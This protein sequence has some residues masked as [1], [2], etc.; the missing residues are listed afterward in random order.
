[1]RCWASRTL[2]HGSRCSS[3]TTR[4]KSFARSLNTKHW[5]RAVATAL[6][7]SMLIPLPGCG[8]PKLQRASPGAPL[9]ETFNVWTTPGNSAQLGIDEFFNDP[10]LSSLIFQALNGN[11]QLKIMTQDIAIANNEIMRRRGAYLPF[12]SFLANARLD[13]YSYNTIQGADNLQGVPISA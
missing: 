9:P 10:I 1:M 6:L 8:I 7:T 13:K 11:L 4:M 12:F 3:G 5:K 2:A